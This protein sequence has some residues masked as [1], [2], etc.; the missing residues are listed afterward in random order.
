MG[1]CGIDRQAFKVQ[2]AHHPH[3]EVLEG[4]RWPQREA[5]SNS[6]ANFRMVVQMSDG[7]HKHR[8]VTG[9]HHSVLLQRVMHKLVPACV[10]SS[11]NTF[12]L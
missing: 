10:L 3:Q 7:K 2:G 6:T 5:L 4:T 11:V 1:R 12:V 9:G 8:D